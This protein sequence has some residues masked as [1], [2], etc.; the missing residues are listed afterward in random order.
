MLW[1]KKPKPVYEKARAVGLDITA[2]RARG[3]AVA[4]GIWR[5]LVLDDPAEDLLLFL[6]LDRDRKSVV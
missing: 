5:P 4:S 1:G 6:A 3:V 2:T